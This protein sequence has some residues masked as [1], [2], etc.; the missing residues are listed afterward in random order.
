MQGLT[1][2]PWLGKLKKAAATGDWDCS[3]QV[4]D[5]THQANDLRDLLS[6]QAGQKV[7]YATDFDL[8]AFNE[9]RLLALAQGA[10]IFLCEASYL[11]EDLD[12]AIKNGHQT[13][14]HAAQLATKAEI[15]KL[16]FFHHSLRYNQQQGVEQVFIDQASQHFAGEVC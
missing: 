10:D 1:P 8:G 13:S 11:Q 9:E 12:L 14:V 4:G 3:L 2:G 5:K 15:K 6:V 16:W 7:V